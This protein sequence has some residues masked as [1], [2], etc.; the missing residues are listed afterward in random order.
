MRDGTEPGNLSQNRVS[1]P[2]EEQVLNQWVAFLDWEFSRKGI[3]KPPSEYD[4]Y[5]TVQKLMEKIEVL[6]Q[7][8]QSWSE[9]QRWVYRMLLHLVALRQVLHECKRAEEHRG[10]GSFRH[11]S[12]ARIAEELLHSLT[13]T[14]QSA[15]NEEVQQIPLE[16]AYE[17]AVFLRSLV[18]REVLPTAIVADAI[19]WVWLE[20]LRYRMEVV[21]ELSAW[22]EL[23]ANLSEDAVRQNDLNL[24]RVLLFFCVL[25]GDDQRARKFLLHTRKLDRDKI[26]GILQI[27][28]GMQAWNRTMDWLLWWE[29]QLTLEE[30]LL[31]RVLGEHW[32]RLGHAF[33]ESREAAVQ[34]F[35]RHR[36]DSPTAEY[37][38][39][40]S[41][42][43]FG[44]LRTWAELQLLAHSFPGDMEKK[45]LRIVEKQGPEYLLPIYH[46]AVERVVAQ[47]NREAY[48]LA[49]RW[50]KKLR[51]YY[52][53]MKRMAEWDLFI[54]SFQVKYARLR[55]LQDELHKAG[56]SE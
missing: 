1:E 20:F 23:W 14:L 7:R 43:E 27:L 42:V 26:D 10:D 39:Q 40:W 34:F 35:Y 5:K 12:Y 22:R 19:Q 30:R 49:V 28:M 51:G 9:G 38:Y 16:R 17:L 56:I 4:W 8:T 54:T 36:V 45:A 11:S 31:F 55:A 41:L 37:F 46:Q 47:K 48:R 52:K 32:L 29:S 50:L 13:A 3:G 21:R 25:A 24:P 33:A 15:G 2:L 44:Q 6:F 18:T 53:K